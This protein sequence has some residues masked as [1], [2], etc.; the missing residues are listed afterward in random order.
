LNWLKMFTLQAPRAVQSRPQQQGHDPAAILAS[1]QQRYRPAPRYPKAS[2]KPDA[3]GSA[4]PRRS[5]T[6][7]SVPVS[8]VSPAQLLHKVEFTAIAVAAV[9][10]AAVLVTTALHQWHQAQQVAELQ[11]QL[12]DLSTAPE[13]AAST[14]TDHHKILQQQG[15]QQL[16]LQHVHHTTSHPAAAGLHL[17]TSS[18]L[19]V[20]LLCGAGLRQLHTR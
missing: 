14:S 18:A 17:V 6:P 15:E 10:Q 2:S 20:G 13:A 16:R 3:S 4:N 12:L 1:P 7:Q 19:V 5:N 11:A 9:C 8:S